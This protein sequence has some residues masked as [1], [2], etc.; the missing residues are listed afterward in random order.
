[1]IKIKGGGVGNGAVHQNLLAINAVNGNSGLAFVP[2]TLGEY[3][4]T[5]L[6]AVYYFNDPKEC[7]D[8]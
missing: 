5:L 1:M 2:H 4:S 7:T 3:K 8:N 6:E